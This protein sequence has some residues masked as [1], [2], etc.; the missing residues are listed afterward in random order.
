MEYLHSLHRR[1]RPHIY[2]VSRMR[3]PKSRPRVKWPGRWPMLLELPVSGP[4][5][6]QGRRQLVGQQ[7]PRPATLLQPPG[8]SATAGACFTALLET[9]KRRS[10]L[11]PARR[12]R[13]PT[14]SPVLACWPRLLL[15]IPARHQAIGHQSLRPRRPQWSPFR[16]V[17]SHPSQAARCAL[18]SEFD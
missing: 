16:P 9:Q 12:R 15:M 11:Q 2:R 18:N 8:Q 13:L 4:G 14:T 3:A 7:L 6:W 5:H 17:I 10:T 1:D